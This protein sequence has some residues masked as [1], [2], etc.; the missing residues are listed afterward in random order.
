M[1]VSVRLQ[2]VWDSGSSSACNTCCVTPK[3][4]RLTKGADA[5]L[6]VYVVDRAGAKVD[7]SDPTTQITFTPRRQAVGSDLLF[8]ARLAEVVDGPNGIAEVRLTSA[9]T[10]YVEPGV[11]VYDLWMTQLGDL[12]P[13]IP[14]GQLVMQPALYQ[15]AGSTAAYERVFV[16]AQI[17]DDTDRISFQHNLDM[18]APTVVIKNNLNQRADLPVLYEDADG[19][20]SRNWVTINFTG[21]RPIEGVWT[22]SV[23]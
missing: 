10:R 22:V 16:D 2:G 20:P 1:P 11:Y 21:W 12:Q 5:L 14:V 6:R 17:D 4:L 3:P 9:D 18:A 8:P 15:A 13:L 7:L 23:G 19:N